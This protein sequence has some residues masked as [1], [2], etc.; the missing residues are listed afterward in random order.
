MNHGILKLSN[1]TKS[2]LFLLRFANFNVRA[3]ETS[4]DHEFPVSLPFRY[5]ACFWFYN[6]FKYCY[7]HAVRTSNSYNHHSFSFQRSIDIRK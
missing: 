2:D 1:S 3:I 4:N 7:I 6:G 5:S